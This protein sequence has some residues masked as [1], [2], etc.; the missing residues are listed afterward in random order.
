MGGDFNDFPPGPVTFTLWDRLHDS[1]ARR[2]R[3]RTYPSRFP[4]LRLD[5]VYLSTEIR[6][7]EVRV[8]RSAEFKRASD[9]LP[10]V[11]DLEVPEVL[12]PFPADPP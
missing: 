12:A 5:R 2:R 1:S 8:D 6:V 7:V 4:L 9:H 11:C 10:V 3:C